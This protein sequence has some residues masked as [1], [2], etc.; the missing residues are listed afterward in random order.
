MKREIQ[1]TGPTERQHL[2]AARLVC[3]GMPDKCANG[4]IRVCG[5][6]QSLRVHQLFGNVEGS[7]SA[8]NLGDRGGEKCEMNEQR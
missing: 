1:L 5:C 3:D 4:K 7:G 6:S 8:I 2:H